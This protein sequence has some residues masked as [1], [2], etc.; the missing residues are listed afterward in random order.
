MN[1]IC[2]PILVVFFNRPDVLRLNLQALSRIAP[3]QMFFACD[4]PRSSVPV[5]SSRVEECRRI[6]RE[7][8]DWDCSVETL[9]ADSNH[10]CDS[11]IPKAVSW[12][13]SRVDAGIILE[14]DCVIDSGFARYA[15]ELLEKFRDD[16]RVMSISAANF[17][18]RTWGEGDYYFSVY[19]SNWGWAT[20]ARAWKAYDSQLDRVEIFIKSPGFSSLI[21]N[22]AQRRYWVRFYRALRS[23]KYTFWD[24]K[25]VLSIWAAGGLAV[26]PNQNMVTNVGFGEDATHT[27]HDQSRLQREIR[28]PTFPLR[29][30]H[31]DLVP[32]VAADTKHFKVIYRP[33]LLARLWQL[34]HLV[35][36]LFEVGQ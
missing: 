8:V 9:Y 6:A 30:P 21:P 14:D 32:C 24:S 33:R 18:D 19:P 5:D 15:A 2:P 12:F 36:R 25:W 11:W 3:R 13:F 10:G 35:S 17:Q 34:K 23:G 22:S 29:H 7:M 1:F 31:T 27:K 4:G 28:H 20:W 26:G 16:P